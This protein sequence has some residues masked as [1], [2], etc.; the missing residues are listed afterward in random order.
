MNWEALLAAL[1]AGL[2]IWSLYSKVKN[3][4]SAFSKDNLGKSFYS[5]GLLALALIALIAF[6]VMLLRV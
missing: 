4:P 5:L 6:C 3:D 1:V 2:L